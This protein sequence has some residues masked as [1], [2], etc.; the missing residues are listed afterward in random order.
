ML[1]K[2][3]LTIFLFQVLIS[4]TFSQTVTNTAELK[5]AA[6]IHAQKENEEFSRATKMAQQKGWPTSFKTP[7]GNIAFLIRI[8]ERG[9]PEY[10]ATNSNLTA[11]NTIGTSS[12]WSGGS[13]G[14]NLSG[15]SPNVK[16]KMALWDGGR[17]R[18]DHTEF[19]NRVI[20]MDNPAALDDHATHVAGTMMASGVN[21]NAKGMAHGT[22]S[23]F[24][25]D[26]QNN[27]DSEMMGMAPS[28][29]VSN[30]SYGTVAGWQLVNSTTWRFWG[31][32]GEN[33]DYK[34]GY[35]DSRAQLWDSIAY[36]SPYYL[37]VKSSGNNRNTN[38]PS[39]GGSFERFDPATNAWVTELR[40]ENMKSNDGYDII[41][42]FGT[43]KNILTVGAVSGLNSGYQ[44]ANG[45]LM[46][47][48]SSWGPT[49]DGRIKPDLVAMGVGLFSPVSSSTT[50]YGTIS[51][52]SMSAP[53]V[54]GSLL[55]L[56]EYYSQLYQ[57][58][59]MRAATLKG[60]AIHTADEAGPSD[61][62]D[63]MFGW[64]LMNTRK[65]ANVISA[66]DTGSHRIIESV[67][68]NNTTYSTTVKAI[69]PLTVTLSW[70]DPRGT[71]NSNA[72]NNPSL[73][74]IHDLDIRVITSTGT[75][76]PWILDPA[77]PSSPATRGDNFRDNV[78]KIFIPNPPV[79]EN[80][81][82]TVS[83]KGNLL[84]GSQA[85]SLI[86][87][88]IASRDNDMSVTELLSPKPNNCENNSQFVT[89]RLKNL[90]SQPKSN[91]PITLI[92]RQGTN[93]IS[94][95]NAVYT[96][97]ITL[98]N[99][100]DYTFQ[101]PV[102]LAAGTT[103]NFQAVVTDP[104]DESRNNDTLSVNVN[105]EQNPVAPTGSGV[106]C[107]NAANLRVS[108]PQS[109]VNFFWYTGMNEA[110]P[111][112]TGS[113]ASTT[114]IPA[115]NTYYVGRGI[116]GTV[117]LSGK[118]GFGGSYI[119]S[120][121]LA[122]SQY[123]RYTSTAP[124]ILETAKLYIK[125]GGKINFIVANI[126]G[127]Q[128]NVLSTT[129]IDVLPSAATQ[130]GGNQPDDASDN[131]RV[132]LL[133]LNL[134]A[135]DNVIIV[136]TQGDANIFRNDN[137]TGNPYPFTIPGVISFT[138]N[139]AGTNFQNFY[140]FLYDMKVRTADCIS[141][142]NSVVV[143]NAPTPVVTQ[144]SNQLVSSI[145]FGNQWFVNNNIII[146]ATSKNYTPAFSG[147]Y[148]VQVTDIYGCQ[149]TSAGFNYV[150]SSLVNLPATEIGLLVSPNPSK[151]SFVIRFNV[152]KRDDVKIEMKNIQG[153]NIY[154]RSLS[155]FQGT[156]NEQ[157]NLQTLAAGVYILRIRQG[158]KVYHQ[159]LVI[160]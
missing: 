56:Q 89:I 86:I 7:E 75:H 14:L 8:N 23:A 9:Y 25:F 106:L 109:G 119:S 142:R 32:M 21:G 26:F 122:T 100:A 151:G 72:L 112:A 140:F 95:L 135:G 18:S 80:I 158:N 57:G 22:L 105:I 118:T 33:E 155:R 145:D 107:G 27:A 77:N 70:T 84:R 127:S 69:G 13:S 91:F 81:T 126:S 152:E 108:S 2:I 83:H 6:A 71:V 117:G 51:G 99:S 87:S 16:D 15:S 154:E 149:M 62:P 153:Q 31:S 97:T 65:A 3:G 44:S 82:I 124:L 150:V 60:L 66:R 116:R 110:N 90:G 41:S 129:T 34:F 1:K 130:A 47:S 73:K 63:Y 46:S 94:S 4:T 36:N 37:I 115:G 53:N 114:T 39:I 50:A 123:M 55:L 19:A 131:G 103:Y 125:K 58:N 139:S 12:L 20:Q 102:N 146:G 76:L 120:T 101:T 48:F 68:N 136:Q 49:D 42:T 35:Y 45:V 92:V 113:S 74:L 133:N 96:G 121:D 43:A 132:Y 98:G 5:R 147:N 160:E 138:G 156:F 111:V 148:T 52:T 64:G 67:L 10:L 59:F 144:S 30:H 141:A 137:V 79:G 61:G 28:L 38:G 134:P 11:A 159:K 88:G 29:L 128:V 40:T 78:E 143:A 17:V 157:L 24:A 93:V 104:V 85:F 54:T